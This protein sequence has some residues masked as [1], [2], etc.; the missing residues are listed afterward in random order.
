M[1]DI[2]VMS[3]EYWNLF[4]PLVDEALDSVPVEDVQAEKMDTGDSLKAVTPFRESPS[5]F[6]YSKK[7]IAI[8]QPYPS[9]TKLGKGDS[10]YAQ[11]V[12]TALFVPI[13]FDVI[14]PYDNSDEA[15]EE[16]KQYIQKY[17]RL[18]AFIVDD[19]NNENSLGVLG[20]VI[21]TQR[22][23]FEGE[24]FVIVRTFC[25]V[26]REVIGRNLFEANGEHG[27]SIASEVKLAFPYYAPNRAFINNLNT[28]DTIT[29]RFNCCGSCERCKH[30]L[31]NGHV[32]ESTTLCL[33]QKLASG[34]NTKS[35]DM[36]DC[37]RKF[38]KDLYPQWEGKLDN[39]QLNSRMVMNIPQLEFVTMRN[40]KFYHNLSNSVDLANFINGL[41]DERCLDL[42][43][44]QMRCF[45]CSTLICSADDA[46]A[47]SPDGNVLVRRNG[48]NILH[49]LRTFKKLQ[50]GAAFA[51][52]EPRKE[53]TYFEGYKWRFL[54]CR[55][56]DSFLG[57]RFE[58]RLYTPSYFYAFLG[59]ALV[60]KHP[61]WGSEGSDDNEFVL[62]YSDGDGD[63][64]SFDADEE[65]ERQWMQDM[66]DGEL[67][68]YEEHYELEEEYDE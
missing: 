27:P 10:V 23:S 49:K 1:D 41:S 36:K 66:E 60:A 19:E 11:I 25:T 38:M 22:K 26:V 8:P 52:G 2:D 40:H 42:E 28:T 33:V 5:Y 6:A 47:F 16:G 64:V 61:F 30:E 13:G 14:V 32:G 46:E 31:L 59:H 68:E 62:D 58:S 29:A 48:N 21:A 55:V 37:I 63:N 51:S 39:F 53:L 56:C 20:H 50:P 18:V 44:T 35:L 65:L 7:F 4:E 57:W 15:V 67:D 9:R 54:N 43:R 3:D 12:D 24:N 34:R 17:G 45:N